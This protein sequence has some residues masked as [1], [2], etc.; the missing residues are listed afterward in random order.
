MRNHITKVREFRSPYGFKF[1]LTAAMYMKYMGKPK[2]PLNFYKWPER[3]AKY[4]YSGGVY[5]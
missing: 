3:T 1:P 4:Y 2:Y 5:R